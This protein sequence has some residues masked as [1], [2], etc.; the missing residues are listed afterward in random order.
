MNPEEIFKYKAS[1]VMSIVLLITIPFSWIYIPE[2]ELSRIMNILGS[3]IIFMACINLL[4]KIYQFKTLKKSSYNEKYV[5]NIIKNCNK[6]GV[7]PHLI[8][9]EKDEQG[10]IISAEI[11]LQQ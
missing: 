11:T 4:Y 2:N 3:A 6:L 9:L 7:K 1:V 5:Q 8:K 10:F